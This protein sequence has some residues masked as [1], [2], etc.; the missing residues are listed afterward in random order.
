MINSAEIKKKKTNSDDSLENETLGLK[1]LKELKQASYK[2]FLDLAEKRNKMLCTKE[3]FSNLLENL[4]D[5]DKE[6]FKYSL[7]RYRIKSQVFITLLFFY[8]LRFNFL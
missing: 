5:L 4:Q 7:E 8:N 1:D 2:D 3:E 6:I